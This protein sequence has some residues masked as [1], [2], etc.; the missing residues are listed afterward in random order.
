MNKSPRRGGT[1]R[2]SCRPA[3]VVRGM[4]VL[5]VR[6]RK[7]RTTIRAMAYAMSEPK[8]SDGRDTTPSPK[9]HGAPSAARSWTDSEDQETGV[10]EDQLGGSGIIADSIDI[11][12]MTPRGRPT[13]P[14]GCRGKGYVWS[15]KARTE[16]AWL[17]WA[18]AARRLSRP[19]WD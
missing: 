4:R 17:G 11:A 3:R 9:F 18:R 15:M 8:V 1:R 5:G 14:T 12:P 19:V 16:T 7:G 13:A 2:R 6:S 10:G